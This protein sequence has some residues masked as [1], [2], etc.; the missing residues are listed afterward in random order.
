MRILIL[1]IVSLVVPA[2]V[3]SAPQYSG[4]EQFVN[5]VN[6]PSDA[7]DVI[8]FDHPNISADLSRLT[9]K[10][11][12]VKLTQEEAHTNN[13]IILYFERNGAKLWYYTISGYYE[14]RGPGYSTLTWGPTD[15]TEANIDKLDEKA[16]EFIRDNTNYS[17]AKTSLV[18]T[19]VRYKTRYYGDANETTREIGAVVLS[20]GRNVGD[21][22]LVGG[23]Y[24]HVYFGNDGLIV[25]VDV[26]LREITNIKGSSKKPKSKILKKLLQQLIHDE[27]AHGKPYMYVDEAQGGLAY[28]V[29]GNMKR[30]TRAILH[31]TIPACYEHI[32]EELQITTCEWSLLT[33]KTV[34][35]GEI[36]VSTGISLETTENASFTEIGANVDG[37]GP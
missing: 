14:W 20:Y 17:P 27:T 29:H 12:G 22:P 2:E 18:R 32:D 30:H 4:L 19:D 9:K 13:G 8:A 15:P 24:A 1:S 34:D 11:L 7:V 35:E 25:G 26:M 6:M 31:A 3:I 37:D 36:V 16:R 5:A 28:M 21:L 33:A 23:D 10:L